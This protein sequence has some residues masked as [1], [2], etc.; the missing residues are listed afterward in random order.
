MSR[1]NR[2]RKTGSNAGMTLIEIMV[3]IAIL[4]LIAGAVSV[5]VIRGCHLER[6]DR[7]ANDI[8]VIDSALKVYYTRKGHYPDTA[9][10]LNS[11]W[12]C[13]SSSAS[14]TIP[15]AT[16]TFTHSKGLGRSSLRMVGTA[17]RAVKERT[18]TSAIARSWPGNDL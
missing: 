11:L 5:N 14:R 10:G 7:A 12:S 17:Y 15:G 6:K 1:S 16:R 13:K 3:V 8:K 4:G 2:L 9:S 18:P